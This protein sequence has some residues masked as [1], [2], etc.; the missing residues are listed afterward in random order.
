MIG[1]QLS[2][3]HITDITIASSNTPAGVVHSSTGEA[4]PC[5]AYGTTRIVLTDK[6]GIRFEVLA[7]REGV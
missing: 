1:A 2:L 6:E 4:I 3:H 7:F 5:P